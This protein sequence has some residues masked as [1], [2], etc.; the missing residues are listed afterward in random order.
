M[1]TTYTDKATGRPVVDFSKEE[2][3]GALG[4]SISATS[5][6]AMSRQKRA[7]MGAPGKGDRPRPIADKRRYDENYERIFGDSKK[8]STNNG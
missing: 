8:E 2:V 6:R 5:K 4:A 1:A 7:S 3:A